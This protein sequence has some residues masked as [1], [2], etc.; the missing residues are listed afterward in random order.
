MTHLIR[1]A[2]PADIAAVYTTER[3]SFPAP[4]PEA[5]FQYE[6]TNPLAVLKVLEVDG[7]VAGYY[8]LWRAADESHLLNIAVAPSYRRRRYG[9]ALLEDAV[10]EARASGCVRMILEVRAGNEAA[11]KLY[12][13]YGFTTVGRRRNYYADGEDADVMAV[14]L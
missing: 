12:V 8:D 9:R 14:D 11:K 3:A 2:R 6:L 10:A 1:P 5:A 4:W 13:G 7:D